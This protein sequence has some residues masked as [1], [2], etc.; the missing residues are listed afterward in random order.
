ML[1][2]DPV[3]AAD[4]IGHAR[5]ETNHSQQSIKGHIVWLFE[6][7]G[8]GAPSAGMRRYF[9]ISILGLLGFVGLLVSSAVWPN[10]ASWLRTGA[11]VWFVVFGALRIS[12]IRRP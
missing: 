12:T 7:P 10:Q 9:L 6:V 11:L 5:R 3:S 8:R 1:P 4:K 2:R